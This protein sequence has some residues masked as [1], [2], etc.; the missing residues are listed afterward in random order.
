MGRS[1]FGGRVSVGAAT[2]LLT[3]CLAGVPLYVS[4]SATAALQERMDRICP[5]NA[6]LLAFLSLDNDR[7]TTFLD[8]RVP[9]IRHVSTRIDTYDS[10]R[11][12][13]HTVENDDQLARE[14]VLLYRSG[15]EHNID[16]PVA[17]L[18]PGEVLLPDYLGHALQLRSGDQLRLT[19][20]RNALALPGQTLEPN[21]EFPPKVVTIAGTYTPIPVRPTPDFW[22]GI[23]DRLVPSARGDA[24]PTIAFVGT[25]DEATPAAAARE[26]VEV[27]VE[28]EGLTRHDA[29][30]AAEDIDRLVDDL[31]KELKQDP[32]VF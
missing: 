24:P 30:E 16:G 8:E 18:Q 12:N 25:P 1:G 9:Q 27:W 10:Y 14:L 4:S 2:G 7:V 23:Q 28:R 13:Y 6:G 5:A 19:A 26:S 32:A 21:A 17:D 3:L 15:Q 22:C 29:R 20:R 31:A 11:V